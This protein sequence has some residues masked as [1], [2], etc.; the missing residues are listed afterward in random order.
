MYQTSF[1]NK[2]VGL[3]LCILFISSTYAQVWKK[4]LDKNGIQV[5]TKPGK[6]GIDDTKTIMETTG[7]ANKV[8]AALFNFAQYPKWVPYCTKNSIIKKISDSEFVYHAFLQ[9]PFVKN[10]DLVIHIKKRNIHADMIILELNNDTS[11]P[12]ETDYTRMP[13][14]YG[15]YTIINKGKD[16]VY[17]EL[18]NSYDPG[19]TVPTFLVNLGLTK[20][21]Y[22]MFA[23]LKKMIQ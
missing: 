20:S 12:E 14:Y 5:Y 6:Q 15:K 17:V 9:I 22:D 7:N 21:P 11:I 23:N 13:F 4:A 1:Y 2:I 19:G 3:L 8:V 10:R 16:Q 18:E